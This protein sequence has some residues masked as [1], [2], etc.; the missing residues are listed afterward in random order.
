MRREGTGKRGGSD[1]EERRK[2]EE[3][4]GEEGKTGWRERS[5]SPY[6]LVP[7]L[8]DIQY[9]CMS[10]C[11]YTHN[12]SEPIFPPYILVPILDTTTGYT[13]QLCVCAH[14]CTHNIS[15]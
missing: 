9:S 13:V 10:V 12:I 11:M 3:R 14:V 5:V 15:T 7:S 6:I 2:K 1:R 4:K 8:L